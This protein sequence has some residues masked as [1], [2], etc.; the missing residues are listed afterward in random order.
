MLAVVAVE[1]PLLAPS[2]V[3]LVPASTVAC[4]VVEDP[5]LA[6][7]PVLA[8]PPVA[9][10]P[11]ALGEPPVWSIVASSAILPSPNR[12]RKNADNRSYVNYIHLHAQTIPLPRKLPPVPRAAAAAGQPS[13]KCIAAKLSR[14]R[15]IQAAFT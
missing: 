12:I 3:V 4:E 10:L 2:T 14:K 8:L 9:M 1:P 13:T 15:F 11:P 5:E 6:E 7:P